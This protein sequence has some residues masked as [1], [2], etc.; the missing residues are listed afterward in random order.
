ME[1]RR[2]LCGDPEEQYA[3]SRT[4]S[5]NPLKEKQAQKMVWLDWSEKAGE[6]NE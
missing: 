6:L 1:M 3:G 4:P 5:V 2:P